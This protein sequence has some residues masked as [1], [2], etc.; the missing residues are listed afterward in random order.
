MLFHEENLVISQAH[1]IPTHVDNVVHRLLA[2]YHMIASQ[3]T[4][5]NIAWPAILCGPILPYIRD[6]RCINVRH[7]AAHVRALRARNVSTTWS[8]GISIYTELRANML[9]RQI[10]Q[11]APPLQAWPID[12]NYLQFQ[13]SPTM[14]VLETAELQRMHGPVYNLLTL[15]TAH[16]YGR[17]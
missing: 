13:L 5:Y 9:L 16:N 4:V 12:R 10:P 2:G 3:Q 7:V 8:S 11:P 15:Y 1:Y 6:Y 14:S 17:G